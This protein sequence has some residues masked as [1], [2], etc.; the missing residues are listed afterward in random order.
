MKQLFPFSGIMN[1]DDPDSVLSNIHHRI[2]YN[3]QFKGTAPNMEIQNIPGTRELFNSLLINDGQNLTIGRFYD[4]QNKRI[5]FFNYRSDNSKAIY[6]YDTI[7]KTFSRIVQQGVNANNDVLNLT[8]TVISNISMVYGDSTQGDILCFLDGAGVPRKVNVNRALTG[9]Y[10]TIQRQYLDI[11]KQP[12]DNPPYVVYENDPSNRINNLRKRLFRFKVRWVFDDKDKSVTSSQSIMPIPQNAFDPQTDADPTINCRIA[13]VFQGGPPNVTKVEILASNFDGTKMTDFYL[14]GT[15]SPSTG[16]FVNTFNTFLFYNDQGYT[17]I[18]VTESNQLQDF[19][20]QNAGAQAVLNGNVMSYGN[21]T[22]GYA[23]LNIPFE[24][25]ITGSESPYYYGNYFTLMT[26]DQGNSIAGFNDAIHITVRGGYPLGGGSIDTYSVIMTNGTNI[27]YASTAGESA[28]DIIAGL[29]ADAISKSYFIINSQDTD[30]YV[31][32][33][34]IVLS[35]TSIVSND[36]AYNLLSNTS[37]NAYDWS[38]KYGFAQVY[39]DEKGRTPQANY[40]MNYS[41]QT[42]AYNEDF[43]PSSVPKIL[44]SIAHQ[45]PIWAKYWQW[46]RTVN[47]TKILRLQWITDRTF[48]DATALAGLV[49]YAYVSI[50]SVNVFVTQNPGSP[51]GYQFSPGDRI[52]FMKRY[53]GS[54]GTA[55]LYGDTKDF[56]ITGSL[57]NPTINGVVQS[58]QFIKFV[59]P[60]TDGTFDFGDGFSNYFIELYTPAQPAAD[61][62]NVFFEFGERYPVLNPGTSNRAHGGMLQDQVFPGTPAT[63]AFTKGDYYIRLR[64]IQTGNIYTWNI[65][66]SPG[67]GFR[68]IIPLNFV[69]STYTDANITPRSVA[70]AGVGGAFNPATD[71]R[72]FLGVGAN[73]TIFKVG[74][75]ISLSFPTAK[76]GDIWQILA[77]NRSGDNYILVEPFDASAAGTYS[78]Q[79]TTVDFGGTISDSISLQSDNLFLLAMSVNFTSDRSI[80]FLA[81]TFTL[82]VD[83]V[84]NQ[85]CIDPNFSDYSPS[86]GN[87]NGRPFVFDENANQVTY[88]TLYRWS[89]AYQTDTNINRNSRFYFD[90]GDTLLRDYGAIRRMMIWDKILTFFQDRKVGQVGVFGKFISDQTGNQQLITTDT[91]IAKD[92]VQYYSGDYGVGNQGDSVVQS[93]FVYYFTDPIKGQQLRLSR[94]GIINISELYKTQ[95]WASNNISKYLQTYNYV[96]GGNARITGTFNIRKDNVGEYLCVLLPGTNGSGS[97]PA[98][99]IAFDESR[100]SFTSFYSLGPEQ[101]LCAENNLYSWVNGKMYIHDVVSNGM[102]TFYGVTYD[103]YITRVLDAALAEGKNW[104]S[105]T[106]ISN[107]IWD[108]PTIYTN[109]YSYGTIQQQS[110]LITDDF[111]QF[112]GSYS[113]SFWGDTNSIGGLLGDFLKGNYMSITFRAQ[114]PINPVTFSAVY[115]YFSDSPL[116]NK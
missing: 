90:N 4:A 67:V 76:S 12:A 84:I 35:R 46:V 18:D 56:E 2:A 28:S 1:T 34:G 19:V 92:N 98:Q 89:L 41:V 44:A 39:F 25:A 99:T 64:A 23:N 7:A 70:L 32:K 29:T 100:N 11:A 21:I 52:K 91:I 81:S 75:S 5:F 3:I 108:C 116:T 104:L 10:G 83:H 79:I 87:S 71:G 102:N 106:E 49:K 111:R 36:Y 68:F 6:M 86:A 103:S 93:G 107:V 57:T 73:V 42:I 40:G 9:G 109:V 26:A 33:S 50:E 114:S 15:M 14:I 54:G 65:P 78:F 110:N 101:I 22:E 97:V 80:T 82:T 20:P 48:K 24:S 13:I 30:L 58:G 51:L 47:L 16:L 96:Y 88:P 72:W 31:S 85:R 45:P 37:F 59:L 77:I 113:A 27:S 74:G 38:S 115:V 69:S 105:L 112:E 95:T 55:T 62:I 60:S 94:D 17:N 8:T 61:G 66:Q 53:D 43:S 63:F